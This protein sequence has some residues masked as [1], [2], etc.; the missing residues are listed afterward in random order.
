MPAT[1]FFWYFHSLSSL[2]V[3][4]LTGQR[5]FSYA[6]LSV[7]VRSSH[8]SNHLW[9]LTSSS[10]P[11]DCVCVCTHAHAYMLAQV[12]VASCWIVTKCCVFLT[13]SM[14]QTFLLL[15]CYLWVWILT[16]EQD[17]AELRRNLEEKKGRGWWFL[18]SYIKKDCSLWMF[19]ALA[20]FPGTTVLAEL[21]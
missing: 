20:S 9:N 13:V 12:Q 6:A 5:S 2:C 14:I 3:L 11:I 8:L 1:L 15:I 4:A 18:T 10:Y 19:Q 7:R 21:V 17:K 16:W